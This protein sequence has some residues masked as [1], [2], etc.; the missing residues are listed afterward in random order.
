MDTQR[1]ARPAPQLC[2]VRGEPTPEEIAAVTAILL[3]LAATVPSG[4]AE[5]ADA[6]PAAPSP[7]W[8]RTGPHRPA[9]AWRTYP[10]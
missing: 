8:R 9:G 2:V 3:R 10:Q 4:P 1:T 7:G 5:H 6:F